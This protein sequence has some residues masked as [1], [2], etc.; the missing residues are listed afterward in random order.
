M[1]FRVLGPVEVRR[2]GRRVALSGAKL[3][4]VLA[5][6]L[7]AREEVI[8]DERLCRLLWGWAPPATVSAQLY[9]YVS[10]LRK[11]LGDDVLIDRRPPGYAMSIGNATLDLNEFEKLALGGREALLAEDFE[12]AGELLRGALA[13][14]NG[15]PFANATEYL[16]DA[17][18]PRL[19]EARAVTLEH[20]I[21]ADLALGRHEQITGELTG[22]V[23]EF[24]LRERIRCQL[25]TALC[26]SGRQADAIHLYHHGRAVLADELGVNPGE[27][28]QATYRALL[29]GTLDRRPHT[30]PAAPAGPRRDAAGRPDGAPAMLPPDTVDFTG[31]EPELEL[32]CR[33]LA[34]DAQGTGR[35]RRVLVTGMAGLGK[36]ALAVHAAHRCRRHF[37][38]G[39]LYADLRAPDGTPRHPTRVLR[40]LL[41]ALG[42]M[43]DVPAAEDQDQ[44]VRLYR[45]RT[46]G[47]QLLIV[48]DNASGAAQ[49]GPLLPNT[50]EPAVLV[51][52]RT[53]LP[54]VAGAHTVALAPLAP[55]D[56][57][58]LLSAAAGPAR[59]A[60]AP[61]AA[62]SIVEHCAGLPL[63]LR[64]VGTRIAARPHSTPDR[65]AR[66]LADP[67]TR[68]RELHSGDLDVHSSLLPSWRAL[69]AEVRSVFP[70]LA[71]LGPQ[72]FP[73]ADAAMSLSL[74]EVEAERLL[75]ALADAAL[76]EV[77]GADER[78]QPCYLFHPLVRLFAL[79]LGE[80]TTP[81]RKAAARTEHNRR[82]T[83]RP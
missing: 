41:R 31:R 27:E 33:A 1:E 62:S 9:T 81:D 50:P 30:A 56:S 35:P 80:G 78:G 69:D 36:T 12:K 2:D 14:W 73:A 44:L 19:T 4:T 76:L 67:V 54:T 42:P 18:A 58:E 13:R 55:R 7:V 74:P 47:K 26:R 32:L 53:A 25:M 23:A 72:P 45:E 51:T 8:S 37:P 61:G 21:A 71:A 77:S 66:R 28:L 15:L 82:L 59:V 63:A 68:L 17:E 20:R 29:E 48:L 10:R 70:A 49:L 40:G 79:S 46:R 57:L 52:G 83:H 22:L 43:D 75:E 3:H 60:S 64:I 38:D 11:I 24:P 5:A 34:P 16:A 6:L 65:L 39:Q